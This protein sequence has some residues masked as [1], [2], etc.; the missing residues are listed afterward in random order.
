LDETERLCQQRALEAFKLD[1]TIWD[2]NVQCE[3]P[4]LDRDLACGSAYSVEPAHSREL[5]CLQ[6]CSAILRPHDRL[7][8]LESTSGHFLSRNISQHTS[9][10]LTVV[11][12]VLPIVKGW[13]RPFALLS[14]DYLRPILRLRCRR[15][16]V[17]Q[18][19]SSIDLWVPIL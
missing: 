19:T 2:V 7:L 11:W 9:S 17:Q 12:P 4:V 16:T 8:T 18:S 13:N 5:S 14:L 1:D 3:Y 15:S 6:A 10:T